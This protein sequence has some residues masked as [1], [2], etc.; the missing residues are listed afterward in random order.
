[1]M[2]PC[3]KTIQ[4]IFPMPKDMNPQLQMELWFSGVIVWK[5]IHTKVQ[6]CEISEH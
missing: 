2:G 1:M 5:Q 3:K 4:D 6:N